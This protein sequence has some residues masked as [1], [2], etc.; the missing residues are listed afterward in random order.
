MSCLKKSKTGLINTCT[1]EK[2]QGW[3]LS[4]NLAQTLIKLFISSF[5]S[6]NMCIRM[7]YIYIFPPFQ[8]VDMQYLCIIYVSFPCWFHQR[9]SSESFKCFVSTIQASRWSINS[10]DIEE[11][12][13]MLY[14][15]V[16]CLLMYSITSFWHNQVKIPLLQIILK[17]SQCE[18]YLSFSHV[19]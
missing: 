11:V 10:W 16:G 2:K 18:R 4:W 6:P 15:P 14:E 13:I 7:A 1:F 3:R 8:V 12:V 19:W 17:L 9:H 5:S